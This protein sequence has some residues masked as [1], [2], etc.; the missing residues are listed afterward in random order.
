MKLEI[1]PQHWVYSRPRVIGKQLIRLK[2][3]QRRDNEVAKTPLKRA[4]YGSYKLDFSHQK[5]VKLK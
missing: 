1:V 4:E 5:S 2:K 3:T